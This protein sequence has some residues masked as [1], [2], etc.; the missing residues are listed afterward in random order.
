LDNRFKNDSGGGPWGGREGAGSGGDGPR[1]PWGPPQRRRPDRPQAGPTAIEALLRKGRERFGGRIPEPAGRPLWLWGAVVFVLL[2]L[3]LTSIHS[4]DRDQR[5][6]IS[7]FGRYAGTLEPGISLTF[8]APIDYVHKL[9][10]DT[11]RS[12]DVG[13]ASQRGD[14]AMLTADR[15]I[16]DVAYS[17]SWKI[18]DP[19]L[20]H[21]GLADAE[22]TIK[23]VAESVMRSEVA[24]TTFDRM[25]SAERDEI[26]EDARARMQEL[27]DSYRA[28]VAVTEV[29][30]KRTD[31]PKEVDEAFK[32]VAQAQEESRNI[33]NDARSYA[34]T[35]T[36]RAQGDAA[37]FDAAYA[38]YKL[39]PQ[40][41]RNRIYFNTMDEVMANTDKIIVD[42][43]GVTVPLSEIRRRPV[44]A[45]QEG[46][47]VVQAKR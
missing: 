30:I 31:P 19:E 18:R 43:P 5:G 13:L 42:A 32:Q 24:G 23:K 6:V 37:Q 12:I 20:F 40:V 2:W 34:Q 46:T 10:V 17:V 14:D 35:S 44:Q 41:T 15:D 21:Y 25:R 7:R 27:L 3:L 39:A 11:V 33:V 28:G 26:A 1:Q 29:T 47:I 9:S 45:S 8:P 38:Q 4:V 22:G 16:V 36:A